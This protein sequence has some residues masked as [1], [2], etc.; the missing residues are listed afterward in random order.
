MSYKFVAVNQIKKQGHE[1]VA[2][3]YIN[4]VLA[5]KFKN[6]PYIEDD[7]IDV[8]NDINR[9]L[10]GELDKELEENLEQSAYD[11]YDRISGNSKDEPIE[12]VEEF[13][14]YYYNRDPE[15]GLAWY[16][17]IGSWIAVHAY[18]MNA[19]LT[20]EEI[21]SLIPI[22]GSD[23]IV[24]DWNDFLQ[25]MEDV[26]DS[27]RAKF[28]IDENGFCAF[29]DEFKPEGPQDDKP[30]E[31]K[32]PFVENGEKKAQAEKKPEEK[33]VEEKKVEEKKVEKVEGEVVNTV[34]ETKKVEEKK[35]DK[36][37]EVVSTQVVED[38]PAEK[39]QETPQQ[40]VKT[41]EEDLLKDDPYHPEKWHNKVPGLADFTKIA[42]NLGNYVQYS[43]TIPDWNGLI[44]M[45]IYPIG[46]GT[47]KSFLIDPRVIY[48]DRTRLIMSFVDGNA[49][50]ADKGLIYDGVYIPRSDT[51]RIKK[52]F[53]GQISAEDIAEIRKGASRNLSDTLKRIDMSGIPGG[54]INYFEWSRI[55]STSGKILKNLPE[56]RYRIEPK[57]K[58]VWDIVC[59]GNVKFLYPEQKNDPMFVHHDR[60]AAKGLTVSVDISTENLY[61]VAYKDGSA[62]EFDAFKYPVT[63][64]KKAIVTAGPKKGPEEKI[65][66]DA[67]AV[68]ADIEANKKK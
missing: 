44:M 63:L 11:V 35:Q 10:R 17:A 23:D 41:P 6:H 21:V 5:G 18:L 65:A 43:E 61:F 28:Y 29:I 13:R 64:D 55:V 12:D 31:D 16:L 25:E 62:V 37:P 52:F 46:G 9:F 51:K 15:N 53:L 19:W 66:E 58:G 3:Q 20:G 42:H 67:K 4:D 54:D 59:D 60:E 32:P 1:D 33:K 36:K 50:A 68:K 30:E 45:R 14:L 22:S 49:L 7:V 26:P 40:P 27:I 34:P 8:G 47:E 48:G 39:K 57:G 38:K 24:S 2:K 56:A